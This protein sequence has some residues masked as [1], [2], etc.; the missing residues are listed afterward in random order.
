MASA[1]LLLEQAANPPGGPVEIV[2]G[3]DDG[4]PP[5]SVELRAA[6]RITG[7]RGFVA[8][9]SVVRARAAGRITGLRGHV[10]VPYDV[11]VER[12]VVGF[13]RDGWQQARRLHAGT[14]SRFEQGATLRASTALLWQDGQRLSAG[15]EVRWEQAARIGRV[16][17]TGWQE[18]A[19]LGAAPMLQR[20]EDA[21]RVRSG[22]LQRIEQGQRLSAATAQRLE[23]AVRLRHAV[24]KAFQDAQ[25]VAAPVLSGFR[26]AQHLSRV[27]AQR[28][29]E[30]GKPPAGVTPRPDSPKSEPDPC[31]VPALPADLVFNLPA[32]A[33]LPAHLVFVCERHVPPDPDPEDPQYV[34]P[35]LRVYMTVHTINAVLLPSLERVRLDGVTIS[36]DDDGY[37]WSMSAR[38][39][40]HLMEQLAPVAGLPQRVRIT[41]DGIEWVFVIE[42][43]ERSRKFGERSVQVRGSSVTSLLGA[44]HMPSSIW[45]GATTMTAQQLV[46]QALEFT[47]VTIDWRLDDWQVPA[48][49]WSHQGTPLSVALRVAEA[50]GAVVRSHRTD[51]ALQFAPRYPRMPWAWPSATPNVRMPGQIVTTDTLQAVVNTAYNAVYVSGETHGGVLGHV[52]RAGSAGDVLA[53]QV[54]DALITH[55]LAARQRGSAVLAA[56]AITKRQP[57]TVPLLTGG[58][59]PGLIL[60]GYLIEVVEPGETWRG[61]V[62]GITVTAGM[63]TVR[64]QLEVERAL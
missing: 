4:L 46:A 6:G 52:V 22:V 50:A 45:S 27:W 8:V 25:R 55:E 38:G 48:G 20:F 37:G 42:Q 14:Q 58:T 39:P 9:R 49:A 29:E 62:R 40:I 30:A 5:G 18:G 44:P 16:V 60:P 24:Q 32:D 3:D 15:L 31:Y 19:R 12:P 54:T 51:A 21:G 64:Q 57:I 41:I 43:P 23:Q 33:S 61:L 1:D 2:F 35:L 36:A 28:F 53:P 10:R 63:P 17:S 47:G 59:N 56:A 26:H 13:S 7:L 34:I 11:N